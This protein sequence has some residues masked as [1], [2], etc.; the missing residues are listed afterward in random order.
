MNKG[1]LIDL[2]AS[3]LDLTKANAART[4]DAVLRAISEGIRRDGAVTI[5]GFGSFTRRQRPARTG[6]NPATREIIEIK[7][8]TTVG[9]RAARLLK[10][11]VE[12]DGAAAGRVRSAERE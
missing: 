10:E 11:S 12:G 9:F 8:S 5:A 7:A 4:I 6:R 3:E 2:L 1:E